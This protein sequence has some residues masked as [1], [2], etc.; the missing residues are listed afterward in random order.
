MATTYKVKKGD[1]L[2]KIAD[3][4]Y[5]EFGYSSCKAYMNQLVKL[6]DIS[7]PNLIYIDQVL[8]LDG[9]VSTSTSTSSQSSYVSITHFGL[10]SDADN[11][12]FVTWKFNRTNTDKYQVK[13]QY[14]TAN[15]IWFIGSDST[16][17]DKQSLYNYPPNACEVKVNVKPISKTYTKNN[18]TVSYW[19]GTWSSTKSY[20]VGLLAPVPTPN[21]PKCEIEPYD[22]YVNW[23]TSK[24]GIIS[25][26]T[27]VTAYKLIASINGY[28][29]ESVTTN[30]GE[31]KRIHF[32]MYKTDSSGSKSYSQYSTVY[33]KSIGHNDGD[34]DTTF[35]DLSEDAE[36]KVRC[37]AEIYNGSNKV[38]RCSEWSDY[39]G[40]YKTAGKTPDSLK[41]TK[42]T[43]VGDNKFNVYLEWKGVDT[44]TSYEVEYADNSEYFDSGS[45]T[46]KVSNIEFPHCIVANLDGGK[47]Y[48]FRVKSINEAGN[49]GWSIPISIILGEKPAAPTTWS[50]TTTAIYGEEAILYWLHNSVDGSEQTYA[51]IELIVNGVTKS[52][53]TIS[54]PS[55]EEEPTESY[56]LDT[57]DKDNDGKPVYSDGGNIK[58]RVRTAG[59]LQ[60]SDDSPAYGNWSVT[61]TIDIYAKPTVE[62]TV[63][64]Q[65]GESIDTITTF[66]FIVSATSGPNSQ[67]PIMYHLDIKANE[68]Y[69]TIDSA[70]NS[71]NI[72]EGQTVYSRFFDPTGDLFDDPYTLSTEISAGNVDLENSIGYM[73]TCT[74]T[75]NSGLTGSA[76]ADIVVDWKETNYEPNAEIGI[77]SEFY[78]AS[79]RPY[80][81]ELP[82]YK[83]TKN[84]SGEYTKTTELISPMD[85]ELVQE[86]RLDSNGEILNQL[87]VKTTTGETVYSVTD[88]N[89]TTSYFCIGN[90]PILTEGILLSVYRR[91]VDGSFTEIATDIENNGSTFVTDPHPSLNYAKYRIVAKSKATGSISYYDIPDYQVG[92]TSIIIQW[93]ESWNDLETDNTNESSTPSW[94]GSMLILPYNIKVADSYNTD[95]SLVNYIGRKRPVS[96]YGTH[97]DETSS[98]STDIPKYD[99]ITLNLLRRLAIYTGDVYVREPSGSGYWASIKVSFD[100]SYD[101][102]IIPIKL[103]ITR[104]EGGV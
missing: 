63:K 101:S 91:E 75:M 7:N 87:D 50:S 31:K 13:W 104:V 41:C 100:H 73:I 42:I 11:T 78:T 6:N 40:T 83:V 54:P 99:D 74:V 48:F 28:S 10:Q 90:T 86:T 30:K 52:T 16:V 68:T 80:C 71:V 55:G 88:S 17:T 61:R 29:W 45:N 79:I 15:G 49:S 92:G 1:T 97:L 57:N 21:T 93:D 24:S 58:W 102:V 38:V 94:S 98:W 12:L 43:D 66:P 82:Y 37:R 64:N 56:V 14:K 103:D 20:N 23:T 36:Y 69:E 44:A 33:T 53:I 51:Q 85:G 96:Y 81:E 72:L 70:G 65:N 2:R 18:K 77:D 26:H 5:E 62:I 3:A 59:V 32:Q 84:A 60:N 4:R 67:T 34:A 76:S 27:K 47:T 46:S 95:V 19:T 9:K 25:S 39:S 22:K 89:N 8:K 35:M